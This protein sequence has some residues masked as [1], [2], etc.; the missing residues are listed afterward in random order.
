MG[1]GSNPSRAV[2]LGAVP[3]ES[4]GGRVGNPG[5]AMAEIGPE[6]VVGADFWVHAEA[7]IRQRAPRV[8]RSTGVPDRPSRRGEGR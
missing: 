5:G 6:A 4:G 2:A 3:R 7:A 8:Y 1:S